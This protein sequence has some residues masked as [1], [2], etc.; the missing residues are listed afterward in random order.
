MRKFYTTLMVL[1]L[2]STVLFADELSDAYNKEY[3]FLKAQKAELQSRLTKEKVQQ[4]ADL[5]KAEAKAKTS[6][7]A[8]LNLSET[9]KAKQEQLAKIKE[10]IDDKKG[11]AE[12]TGSVVIQ[13]KSTLET[14]GIA[15]DES[16]QTTDIQRMEQA[17]SDALALYTKLSS[18]QTEKGKFYL[19]NGS[20][21]QGD[22]VKVG[23]IAAYGIAQE[24]AG[25][26]APA[27]NGEYKLWNAV[28]SADDAKAL[29]AKEMRPDLNIFV[30][31]N[32]DKEVE[33][34]KEKTMDDT[35]KAGG[36]IGYVILVLGAFGLLLLLV[37]VFVLLG[38]GSSVDKITGIVVEKV[39]NGEGDS[40]LDAIKN[41]DGSTARVIKATLRNIRRGREHIEDI[42]MENIL[43]EQSKIDR[44]GNFVLV[45]AAVAPLLG[46]LGTVTGMIA[47][48]DVITEY[49][50]G[51]P[52]LLSGGIS[53]AL[54]TT[55][56]GLIV[57]IPLLLIGNM[58]S[59]WAQNIKDSMEH[60]ALHIVNIF[61]KHSTK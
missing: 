28:G 27:G 35:L 60:S 32:L 59:G 53:E 34:Q 38:A 48:F 18:I 37:R 21:A 57:A 8:Y 33:Y 49:G 5:A 24:A 52:K 31:E 23:N 61:E 44:F 47:T 15:M 9:L 17:F 40:A 4:A 6:Q 55:E 25:A 26:L 22:I 46:L 7:D 41:F 10:K 45:I 51:D 36:V 19:P 56:F 11:N 30:Y 12:I 16:N 43:N 13:A 3:T 42:I 1:L 2:S 14:Y 50:T 54:V 58:L 39:E 20:I 29:F